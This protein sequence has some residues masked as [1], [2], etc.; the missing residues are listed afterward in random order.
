MKRRFFSLAVFFTSALLLAGC[1]FAPSGGQGT[2]DSG[3]SGVEE[4]APSKRDNIPFAKG[5]AYAVAHLGYLKIENLDFY[6]QRYLDSE[7]LPV[8]YFSAGDYYLV[9]PRYEGTD[10]ALYRNDINTSSSTLVY[11]EPNCRPFIIQ[12]NVSDIFPDATI[13]LTSEEGTVEF[14][15]F[16]SMKDGSLDVG[17]Q[18]L[19][20]TQEGNSGE[21]A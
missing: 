13:R 8:H 15:P 3:Q 14:S 9:I 2:E 5:Q 21:A 19:D 18:G 7:D 20:L 16:I 17:E 4:T 10:L 12:C 6:T 11:E 1:A